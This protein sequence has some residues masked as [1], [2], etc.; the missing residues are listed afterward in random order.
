[1]TESGE[2]A[3]SENRSESFFSQI[4]RLSTLYRGWDR[5]EEN[6]GCAGVDGVTV[7]KY[8]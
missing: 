3:V 2:L 6:H 5:V 7:E 4:T 8:E 1:M